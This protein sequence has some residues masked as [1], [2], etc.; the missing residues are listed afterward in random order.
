MGK[1]QTMKK[2]LLLMLLILSSCNS[3]SLPVDC[4]KNCAL[5]ELQMC[6]DG[7]ARER[8]ISEKGDCAYLRAVCYSKS[9]IAFAKQFSPE[10]YKK[11]IKQWKKDGLVPCEKIPSYK[12]HPYIP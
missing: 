11:I 9:A 8:C 5:K 3:H 7:I 6:G 12:Q 1:N 2:L 4:S 10:G